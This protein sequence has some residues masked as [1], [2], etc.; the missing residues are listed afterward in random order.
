[1]NSVPLALLAVFSGLS[2]NL[3]LQC[4][5]GIKG[6]AL[7]SGEFK[8]YLLLKT[9]VLFVT[10]LPLWAVF[11]RLLASFSPGLFIYV[12]VFPS[13]A[14]AHFVFEYLA[15]RFFLKKQ[16]L[17]EG[18]IHYSEGLAPAALF[19][20]LNIAGNFIEA[21]VLSLGFVAGILFSFLIL[22]EIRRRAML[23][24]VPRFLRG[25]P[26]V[27]VSMGLLSMIFSAAAIL[28]FALIGG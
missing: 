21:A 20:S 19:I 12:L 8:K 9:A 28:F 27:L 17:D 1:M 2:A 4:G 13:A 7:F 26:L 23:E 16:N 22:N 11:A 18:P 10:I 15:A 6:I 3:I 5:L 14:L 25:S 24:A